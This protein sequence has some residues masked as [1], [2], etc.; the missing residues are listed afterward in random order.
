[1]PEAERSTIEMT[2]LRAKGLLPEQVELRM[3]VRS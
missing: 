2:K 3:A 1:V